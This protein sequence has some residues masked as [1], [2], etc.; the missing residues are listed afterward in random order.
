MVSRVSRQSASVSSSQTRERFA[1]LAS[2]HEEDGRSVLDAVRE[3]RPPF[4][5]ESVVGDFVSLIKSYGMSSVTG[6]R[7]AG[8]WPREQF[9]KAGMEYNTA[10]GA[11][12]DL[13]R[14]LLPL[15]NS[16]KVEPLDVPADR[17]AVGRTGTAHHSRWARFD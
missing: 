6:D 1:P 11:K 8:E 13:Y 3:V 16:G 5:P 10:D 17:D 15:L 7:Y 2:A 9:R 12:S 14:D 4:S